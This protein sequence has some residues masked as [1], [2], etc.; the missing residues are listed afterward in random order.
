MSL[1]EVADATCQFASVTLTPN[2]GIDHLPSLNNALKNLAKA[3][4]N[5]LASVKD[6]AT[7]LP[8]ELRSRLLLAAK[9]LQDRVLVTAAAFKEFGESPGTSQAATAKLIDATRAFVVASYSIAARIK[10]FSLVDELVAASEAIVNL[11]EQLPKS[12]AEDSTA[13]ANNTNSLQNA[14][15]KLTALLRAKILDSSNQNLVKSL[16]SCIESA[17]KETREICDDIKSMLFDESLSPDDIVISPAL[18][19]KLK[20]LSATAKQAESFVDQL[21]P[22]QHPTVSNSALFSP[23]LEQ[24]NANINTH[25]ANQDPTIQSIVASLRSIADIL[26]TLRANQLEIPSKRGQW[27]DELFKLSEQLSSISSATQKVQA[28]SSDPTVQLTLAS[29]LKTLSTISLLIRISA[30]AEAFDVQACTD[31]LS[32]SM[33]HVKDFVFVSFP[34]LFSIRDAILQIEEDQQQS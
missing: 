16:A 27:I 23:V 18:E 11:V 22:S 4:K 1:Q 17:E 12:F 25:T 6:F 33:T 19:T 9:D 15:F 10:E 24:L 31:S 34:V 13:V 3:I 28:S 8:P 20:S 30:P 21:S 2:L 32:R 5:I 14:S 26:N 7:K 29:Y